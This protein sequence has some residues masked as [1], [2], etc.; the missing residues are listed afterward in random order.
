MLTIHKTI[1]CVPLEHLPDLKK[2]YDWSFWGKMTNKTAVV[3]NPTQLLWKNRCGQGK[4]AV[5]LN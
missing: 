4:Y 5:G 1:K 3:N 2:I